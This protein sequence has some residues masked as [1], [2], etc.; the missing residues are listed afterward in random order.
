MK[1]MRDSR[2]FII[3]NQL[4]PIAFVVM[5]LTLAFAFARLLLWCVIIWSIS[6][7]RGLGILFVFVPFLRPVVLPRW[8]WENRSGDVQAYGFVW[9]GIMLCMD[10]IALGLGVLAAAAL[11]VI[12]VGRRGQKTDKKV[13]QV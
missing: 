13:G 2:K 4:N 8:W 9:H 12:V 7:G 10:T 3:L 5:V 1:N 11:L 6:N